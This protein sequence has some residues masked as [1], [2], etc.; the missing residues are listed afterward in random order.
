MVSEG[1]YV[2]LQLEVLNKMFNIKS[3]TNPLQN[4]TQRGPIWTCDR[5]GYPID[6]PV[7]T[8]LDSQ[9]SRIWLFK[10]LFCLRFNLDIFNADGVMKR[11]RRPG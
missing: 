9:I 8:E 6:F 3:V 5:E 11:D 7:L 1:D 10:D 2:N 4:V